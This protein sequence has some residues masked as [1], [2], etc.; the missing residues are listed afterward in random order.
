[1]N[2]MKEVALLTAAQSLNVGS[3]Q[4]QIL[5]V[6]YR[7]SC[8]GPCF[9]KRFTLKVRLN[10]LLRVKHPSKSFHYDQG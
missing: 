1:M 9:R 7:G 8:N 10:T 5:L 3:A 6:V 2:A 4:G